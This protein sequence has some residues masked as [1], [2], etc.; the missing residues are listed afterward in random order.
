MYADVKPPRSGHGG[1]RAIREQQ[2]DRRLLEADELLL[3]GRDRRLREL[4]QVS[5][6]SPAYW[7]PFDPSLLFVNSITAATSTPECFHTTLEVWGEVAH[8]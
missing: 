4:L 7:R 2:R 3:S 5:M 8:C 1:A 6:T